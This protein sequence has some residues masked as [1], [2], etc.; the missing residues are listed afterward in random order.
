M[1][2]LEHFT[3]NKK[4]LYPYLSLFHQHPMARQR[5]LFKTLEVTG[6]FTIGGNTER[7]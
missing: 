3:V 5:Q 4:V 6:T 2:K 1:G 7:L